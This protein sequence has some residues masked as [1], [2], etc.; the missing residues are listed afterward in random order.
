MKACDSCR[1]QN[2][3]DARF[4]L[5]CGERFPGAAG[6]S[7][8]SGSSETESGETPPASETAGEST[9]PG[10][11]ETVS[12]EERAWR[13]LVGADRC[14]Q[15]TLF[16]GWSWTPA[17][18]YYQRKFR[19]FHSATSPRFAPTW[20]W[21]P[22]LVDPFLW[23]LYRKMYM[24]ALVYLV[25]PI[26]SVFWT[27]D[28]PLPL[29]ARLE[30]ILPDLANLGIELECL[31]PSRFVIR[32]APALVGQMDYGALLEDILNDMLEWKSVDSL[33][34]RVRSVLASMAC[35][36]AVQA[37]RTM[38]APE[39]HQVVQDWLRAGVPM[40]CPH[41]RRISLH[42]GSDELHRM[43]RRL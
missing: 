21:A 8:P 36:S 3:D 25:G 26:V 12:D 18:N 43:F 2:P 23:F 9:P 20:N 32:S 4:C 30:D 16:S 42:F 6:A 37:G 41:G 28:I 5:H 11:S 22:F 39:M 14:L 33:D 29:A 40:T 1:Q 10:S 24:F 34:K 38:K 15:L 35:Q 27:G 13:V 19:R 7:A 31:G 17:W